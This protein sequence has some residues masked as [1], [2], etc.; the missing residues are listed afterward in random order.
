MD[1]LLKTRCVGGHIVIYPDKVAI[2]MKMLGS[3]N[4]NALL[5]EQVTGVEVKTTYAK[6]PII[7]RGAATVTIYAK[8]DQKLVAKL[9]MLDDAKKAEDLINNMNSESGYKSEHKLCR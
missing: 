7:S 3:H 1:I 6:I 9:V 5:A 8:G 4:V 2:E